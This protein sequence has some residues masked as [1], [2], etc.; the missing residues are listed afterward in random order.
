MCRTNAKKNWGWAWLTGILLAL[1]ALSFGETRV[2]LATMEPGPEFW[3]RFGHNAIVIE[4]GPNTAVAYNYGYF[5][6]TQKNFV[7]NFALGKMRY[8][9][10]AFDARADLAQYVQQGRRVWV[11]RLNFSAAQIAALQV[12]LSA[13]TTPPNDGYRYDYF[14][15]NCATKVRDALDGALGGLLQKAVLGRSHGYSFRSLG[16][17]HAQGVPWM[18]LGIHAGLGPSADRPLTLY[19]EW[20]IPANLRMALSGIKLADGAPL[21]LD[22]QLYGGADTYVLPARPDLRWWF[23]LAGML[24]AMLLAL[25]FRQRHQ[26]L[27]RMLGASVGCTIAATLGG[28]GVLLLF[29]W[30]GTDHIDTARNLNLTLFCP[31]FLLALPNLLASFR[32]NWTASAT[33]NRVVRFALGAAIAGAAIKVLPSSKQQNLEWVLLVLPLL[34]AFYA[35]PKTQKSLQ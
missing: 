33:F 19:E 15:S 16:L 22:T 8:A 31:L 34:T 11:Q 17:A 21:V 12:Q 25:C 2:Y 9:G 10:I 32:A 13:T 6:F 20:F 14:R 29:L 5:D 30:F 18:F 27:P 24:L 28:G 35:L 1:S 7:L 23:L 4:D 26:W 3:E